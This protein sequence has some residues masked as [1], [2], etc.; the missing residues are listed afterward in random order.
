M[1]GPRVSEARPEGTQAAPQSTE[2]SDRLK[3]ILRWSLVRLNP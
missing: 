2:K 3:D 1:S